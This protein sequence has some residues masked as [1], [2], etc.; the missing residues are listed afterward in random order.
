MEKL[1]LLQDKLRSEV[2][3]L[4]Q[5]NTPGIVVTLISVPS[6]TQFS[7][8]LES[9]YIFSFLNIQFLWYKAIGPFEERLI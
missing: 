6:N 2:H 3:L 5:H 1:N 7:T 9:A 4:P 8:S